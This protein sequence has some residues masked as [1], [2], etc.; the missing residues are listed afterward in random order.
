MKMDATM[1]DIQKMNPKS[2]GGKKYSGRL[3]R[4]VRSGAV[5]GGALVYRGIISPGTFGEN[6]LWIGVIDNNTPG[7]FWFTGRRLFSVLCE[8]GEN[9]AY[10]V[11]ATAHKKEL[12]DFWQRYYEKGRCAIDP[13]HKVGFVD[14]EYRWEITM[15]NDLPQKRSCQWCGSATQVMKRWTE[16]VPVEREEWQS[17]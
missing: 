4:A 13:E 3:F 1:I 11:A 16:M 8:T 7:E 17:A 15:E 12:P 5:L 14:D 10:R 9:C 2:P 6:T